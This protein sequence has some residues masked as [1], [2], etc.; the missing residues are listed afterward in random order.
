M[1]QQSVDTHF[2]SLVMMLASGAWQQMGKVPD[3]M[4]GKVEKNLEQSKMFIDILRMLKEKTK[5][6]LSADED[7]MIAST[8]SD[9][10]LNY[11]DEAGK[12]PLKDGSQPAAAA[13]EPPAAPK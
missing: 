7:K 10:E 11:V 3:Q 9:L 12:T 4:S 1:D 6:N 5:G 13:T 8:V 2:L